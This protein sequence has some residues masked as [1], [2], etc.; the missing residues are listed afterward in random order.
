M[1]VL[2][3]GESGNKIGE[4]SLEKAKQLA[5]DAGKS[6]VLV[7]PKDNIY[8]ISDQ[9]KLKYEQ[10]QKEKGQRAQKR[11]HKVKE[12]KFN[13]TTEQHDIDTKVRKI[14]KFLEDGLKTKITVQLHGRQEFCKDYGLEKMK[15]IIAAAI[16]G[17]LATVDKGPLVED[18]HIIVF[19]NPAKR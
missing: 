13:L 2:V 12:I 5:V 6:L 17:N 7:N 9:G 18:K 15:G 8:K 11:T 10:R 1:N 14:R 3:I 19:L 16:D 4:M